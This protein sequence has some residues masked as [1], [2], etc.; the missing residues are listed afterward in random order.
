VLFLS[1]TSVSQAENFL[2]RLGIPYKY[3]R[4]LIVTYNLIPALYNEIKLITMTQK[5][6]G[7]QFSRNPLKRAVQM[8]AI[9]M[10]SLFIALLRAEIL[11]ISIKSRGG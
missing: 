10:P 3:S 5:A 8:I 7:L 1:T 6:R 2:A 4:V 11:E 9:L